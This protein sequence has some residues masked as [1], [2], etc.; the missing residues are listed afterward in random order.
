MDIKEQNDRKRL[1]NLGIFV[2]RILEL[3]YKHY[4]FFDEKLFAS[5]LEKRGKKRGT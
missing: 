1:K 2:H 5:L 3:Y 4:D